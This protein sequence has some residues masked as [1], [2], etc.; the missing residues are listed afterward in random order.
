[1]MLPLQQ[2]YSYH[3][4]NIYDAS[5]AAVTFISFAD[6]VVLRGLPIFHRLDVLAVAIPFHAIYTFLCRW[7][8]PD[9]MNRT[10]AFPKTLY[11]VLYSYPLLGAIWGIWARIIGK[12]GSSSR[13]PVAA[14]VALA[15]YCQ[16]AFVFALVF[17]SESLLWFAGLL[18]CSVLLGAGLLTSL[19]LRQKQ[20]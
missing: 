8:R 2:L 12:G 9:L 5:L 20:D 13:P 14:S 17:G 18:C 6:V 4:R 7:F 10:I 19:E 15:I 3:A 11:I 16:G 1:M